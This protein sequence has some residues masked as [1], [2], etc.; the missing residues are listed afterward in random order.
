MRN[1]P[2]LLHFNSERSLGSE[3]LMRWLNFRYEYIQ[4]KP[5]YE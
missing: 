2:V 5:I 1:R 3:S 4:A